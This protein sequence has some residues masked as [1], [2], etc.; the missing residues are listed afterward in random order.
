MNGGDRRKDGRT[1]DTAQY[2]K[3]LSS[4]GVGGVRLGRVH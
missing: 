1:K 4:I 3:F 2:A